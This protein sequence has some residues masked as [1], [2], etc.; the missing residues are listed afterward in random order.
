M[1]CNR[2]VKGIL[3]RDFTQTGAPSGRFAFQRNA[4]KEPVDE[5]FFNLFA[6][7]LERSRA[8]D[9]FRRRTLKENAARFGP[10]VAAQERFL[11]IATFAKKERAFSRRRRRRTLF[12]EF[13]FKPRV[14]R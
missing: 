12:N 8:S 11:D 9:E 7:D 3:K 10:V 14:Q 2:G 4:G 1:F 5:E 13:L 6:I